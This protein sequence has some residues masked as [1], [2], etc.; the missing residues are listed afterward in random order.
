MAEKNQL[1]GRR[2]FVV[3]LL[4][5][6]ITVVE[7]LGGLF[8]GSLSLL[9][10]AFHNLGDTFSILIGY[11]AHRISQ[12]TEDE[13]NTFGYGRAQILAAL[14]NA[15]LLIV[16]SLFLIVEAVRRLSQPES[17]D[18]GLMLTVA[19]I[20]L[21]ANLISTVMMHRGSKHNMNMKAT[22]LHLLS[23]TL[24]SFGVIIGALLIEWYNITIVDPIITVL[25]AGYIMFE[26]WPIIRHAIQILMQGAPDID[27]DA[28]KADLK[29]IPGITNVHHLHAWMMDENR[30]VL[31]V[32]VNMDD[33]KLSEAERLYR[34]IEHVLKE[35]YHVY[36]VTIQ[37]EDLR[38][39]DE[40][41]ICNDSELHEQHEH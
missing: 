24:S 13:R 9:S 26:S 25:V 32:H 20:G 27:Y 37:A 23:D 6:G 35:K 7:I 4:N 36:H 3:T 15:T 41:L 11:V 30:I 21:L 29:A 5:A 28:I 14:L 1:S 22:Y 8:S 2:F 12:R 33:M 31:S 17:I 34:Q 19:V 39:H 10:D 16:V 18:G 40:E 38:G